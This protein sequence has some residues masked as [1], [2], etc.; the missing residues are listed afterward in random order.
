MFSLNQFP[1]PFARGSLE[2]YISE[3]TIGF[4]YDKHL[5]GYI[6]NLNALIKSTQF[7]NAPLGQII[8]ESDGKVF[9]NAAQIFNHVFFFA[10]LSNSDEKIPAEI[11]SAFKDF[12]SEF[13]A[14]ALSVFGSGWVWLADNR[15][16]LEI[17]TT[18]NADTPMTRGRKPLLALDVWEHAYYLDY[19]N[20]RGDFCDAFL[21]HIVNWKFVLSNLK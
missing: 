16:A 4:H 20:R 14:A 2:P 18:A 8:K 10:G 11:S 17:M 13:K 7:E 21:D 15:G 12:K 6:D 5:G 1:L 19:Q 3:R 9:N